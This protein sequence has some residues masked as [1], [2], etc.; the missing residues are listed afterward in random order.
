MR[1]LSGVL[2]AL[3]IVAFAGV[4]FGN[5]GLGLA[6]LWLA[7]PG[8]L[9]VE[10]VGPL[11]NLDG[12]WPVWLSRQRILLRGRGGRR[13]ALYRDEMSASQWAALKRRCLNDQLATGRNTSI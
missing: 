4:W 12:L 5:T 2:E 11:F 9:R 10:P 13:V 7:V 1:H 6:A 8:R 3:L